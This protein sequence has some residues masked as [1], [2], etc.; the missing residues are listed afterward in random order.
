MNLAEDVDTVG[1]M[2]LVVGWKSGTKTKLRQVYVGKD[3]QREFREVM[4]E[5]I[6]DLA[7]REPEEW[8]PDADLSPETYLTIPTLELGAA[9]IMASEHGDLL[10]ADLLLTAEQLDPM[11]ARD[12]PASNL[13]FYAILIGNTPTNRA[14]FLRRSNPQRGLRKG[15]IYTSLSDVLVSVEDPI[16]AFDRSFDLVFT[17]AEVRVLSQ[18]VFAA[19]FRDQDAL[20]SQVPIWSETLSEHIPISPSGVSRLSDKAQRDSRIRAR[21]E[22]IVRRGH[23]PDVSILDIKNAMIETGLDPDQL[24]DS[25]D[26]LALEESDIPQMLQFLNEDLFAGILTKIGFRAD[27][28]AAR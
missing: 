23:L 6:A 4:R 10:L 20:S 19:L 22:A 18:T 21:L 14:A 7:N 24:I 17:D 13:S 25:N 26:N 28:K 12:I 1:D 15:R 16:F 5:T 11:P 3:V 9:P 2:T 8:T 27:K